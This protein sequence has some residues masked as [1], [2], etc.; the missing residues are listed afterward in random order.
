[1]CTRVSKHL[2]NKCVSEK[3]SLRA[4][5]VRG[6]LEG[7]R[8]GWWEDEGREGERGRRREE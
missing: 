1:M 5:V 4:T 8:E 7:D 2:F 6:G 3:C